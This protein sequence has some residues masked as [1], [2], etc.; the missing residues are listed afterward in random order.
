M[1]T[2]RK[3]L[4]VLLA[5]AAL[6]STALAQATGSWSLHGHDLGGQRYSLLTAVNPATVSG[7]VPKWTYH[8]GVTAT[9]QTTPIVVDGVMFVSLPFSGVA[10]LDAATGAG[11]LAL[12]PRVADRQALLRAGQPRRRSGGRHGVY[13]DG[14]WTAG[15]TE[16]RNRHKGMGC[17]V[18]EYAGTT[19]ANSQL[20][21]DDLA[22]AGRQDRLDW[23]RH[24]CG[25]A[26]LR[27]QGVR[28]H[29]RGGLRPAPR[30]GSRGGRR[31]WPVRPTGADGRL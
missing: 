8:S 28:R 9:F 29:R 1:N 15:R 23:R 19:E 2:S 24:Q 3:H 25:P 30:P 14:G 26:G 6:P 11:A 27:R 10:A 31:R 16:C 22:V 20:T 4:R 18:A 21:A 12:H 7:L 17:H 13:R 5:L